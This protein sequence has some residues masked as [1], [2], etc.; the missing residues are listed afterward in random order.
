MHEWAQWWLVITRP[1]SET[2]LPEQPPA[3]RADER[4]TLSSH[5]CV[6]EKPYFSFTF[7]AGKSL[8]SHMPSSAKAASGR[9]ATRTARKRFM[10]APVKGREPCRTPGARNQAKRADGGG[11]GGLASS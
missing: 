11:G 8:Y 7:V 10:G 3:S 9:T 4:R 5:S 6:G 2:K 1:F